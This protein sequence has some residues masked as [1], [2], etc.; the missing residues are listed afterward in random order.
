MKRELKL[1]MNKKTDLACFYPLGLP[2]PT[3]NVIEPIF[4]QDYGKEGALRSLKK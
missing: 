3:P 1:L 4:L 2:I